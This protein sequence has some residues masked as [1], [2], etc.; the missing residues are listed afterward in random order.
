MDIRPISISQPSIFQ[1]KIHECMRF[2]HRIECR[3]TYIQPQPNRIILPISSFHHI[4]SIIGRHLRLNTSL[5]KSLQIH[6]DSLLLINKRMHELYVRVEELQFYYEQFDPH[7]SMLI[8]GLNYL[9]LQLDELDDETDYIWTLINEVKH[10]IEEYNR[11]VLL[12][13]SQFSIQPEA[14]QVEWFYMLLNIYGKYGGILPVKPLD[15][16]QFYKDNWHRL[17]D[18]E[19]LEISHITDSI[20]GGISIAN[21]SINLSDWIKRNSDLF[22]SVPVLNMFLL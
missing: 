16:F 10:S 1:D 14:I 6:A 7:E 4:W 8:P 20:L 18:Q 15:F 13:R 12:K 2:L 19:T 17:E 5:S 9:T 11:E 3:C 22:R 21:L